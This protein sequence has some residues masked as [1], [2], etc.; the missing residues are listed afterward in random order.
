MRIELDTK[1]NT[2]YLQLVDEIR[3]GE[4][5]HTI[6]LEEGVYLDLD[7]DRRTL[8]IEFLDADDFQ[9]FLRRCGGAVEITKDGFEAIPRWEQSEAVV[10]AVDEQE[11]PITYREAIA[12]RIAS[13]EG[14][15]HTRRRRGRE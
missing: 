11:V 14:R 9:G 4:A 6:Q 5:V 3:D 12:E 10:T 1:A 8:G 13:E 15:E 2:L 7:K